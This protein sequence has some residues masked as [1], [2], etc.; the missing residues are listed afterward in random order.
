M[1][2]PRAGHDAGRDR[3]PDGGRRPHLRARRHRGHPPARAV[4]DELERH[5]AVRALGRSRVPTRARG[6][7][8]RRTGHRSGRAHRR[9]SVG[10]RRGVVL[11]ANKWDTVPAARRD[12]TRFR[13]DI[14]ALRPAFAALPLLCL[15]AR[16]GEGVSSIFAHVA[17]IEQAYRRGAP[18]PGPQPG[19]APCGGRAPAAER[20]RSRSERP[21]RYADGDAAT[22]R[23]DLLQ[24][25]G[26]PAARL[27]ALPDDARLRD[28]FGL[29]GVPLRLSFRARPGARRPPRRRGAARRGSPRRGTGG[30]SPR[31]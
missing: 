5:G 17:A 13:A 11:L 30:R 27:R 1:V 2:S 9:P 22:G 6:R 24:Q 18:H 14:A 19:A 25:S 10:R 20:P 12:V 7:S 21:L 8:T 16:T 23:D 15:S 31:R 28:A 4:Q 3:H 26:G 29:V